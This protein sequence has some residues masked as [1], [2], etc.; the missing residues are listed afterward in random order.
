MN[1]RPFE[2][3]LLGSLVVVMLAVILIR[4]REPLVR[5]IARFALPA[6]LVLGLAAC[7][8][9][10]Y[11]FR[12]TGNAL[13]MPYQEHEAQYV[14]SSVFM[15]QKPKPVPV[16]HNEQLR[17][18]WAEIDV[19]VD[20]L[21]HDHPIQGPLLK[22]GYGYEFYL[23]H[24]LFTLPLFGLIVVAKNVR[25][26]M[27][28]VLFGVFLLGMFTEKTLWPHYLAP[29]T[30]LFFTLI[31]YGFL[32]LRLWKSGRT[33]IGIALVKPLMIAFYVQ[34]LIYITF[35]CLH[36]DG[37]HIGDGADFAH[38]RAG[39]LAQLE[40]LPGRQ[41]VVVR[42]A[43]N[44]IVHFEWVFNRAD[45]DHAKVVWARELGAA[46][47]RPFVQYFRDRKIWLLEADA[48]PPR[49]TPYPIPGPSPVLT[50]AAR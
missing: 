26:R 20:Q 4:R 44:H 3:A 21:M 13:R 39:I 32:G 49:L 27:A 50:S 46:E 5:V 25:V 19:Q 15:W 43:R 37:A 31:M 10:F 7:G 8:T 9:A 35:S 47:D 22:L 23:G 29:S 34:S 6:G 42:Y 17:Q 33:P 18:L 24:V 11:N 16:Y 12:V 14:V 1:S 30:A 48:H 28:L 41:L 36:W 2:G 38:A 40:K 45:I